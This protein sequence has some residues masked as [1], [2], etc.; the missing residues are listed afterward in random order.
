MKLT[1]RLFAGLKQQL[2]ADELVLEVPDICTC[3]DAKQHLLAQFPEAAPALAS[4]LVAVNRRYAQPNQLLAATD[5]VALIPPVS[6][7]STAYPSCMITEE[8]LSLDAAK[9]ALTSPRHG[10]LTIFAG[11]VREWTGSR[12][13]TLLTYEAYT[14]MALSIMREIEQDVLAEH[15]AVRTIQW[16]RIG[17]MLPTE[18]AVICG[19]AAPHRGE[20]F[21]VARQLIERLKKEVPIW[22]REHYADG[23][24]VWQENK[25]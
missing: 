13:T 9:S 7:G 5:E 17:R 18:T 2:G 15:P 23:E 24:T 22:K 21:E 1:V 3:S 12:Q 20:A 8:A 19:A 14:E 4:A 10:G 6:G 11:T 25:R 16:H